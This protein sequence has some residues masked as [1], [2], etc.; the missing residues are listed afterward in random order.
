M[1]F[2]WDVRV[3]N[4]IG[5]SFKPP[6]IQHCIPHTF[7]YLILTFSFFRISENRSWG[8]FLFLCLASSLTKPISPTAELE[9]GGLMTSLNPRFSQKADN[10]PM[11]QVPGRFH[12]KI[13]HHQGAF[14]QSC[15]ARDTVMF[16]HYTAAQYWSLPIAVNTT[17]NISRSQRA[18]CN[19]CSN[20]CEA[21]STVYVPEMENNTLRDSSSFPFIC[22]H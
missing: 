16:K 13:S 19:L 12:F 11:F 3:L 14:V 2:L 15:V 6:H 4:S 10:W 21:D 7:S 20:I 5:F 1:W 8:F 22:H 9:W 18:S 17:W